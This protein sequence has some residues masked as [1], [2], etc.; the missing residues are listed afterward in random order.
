MA[1]APLPLV[2]LAIWHD[3]FGAV[4]VFGFLLGFVGE[5]LAVGVP[6]VSGWYPPQRQ[7]FALGVYGVGMAGTVI[8]G[9]TAPKLAKV[10]GLG[11][12]FLVG[13]GVLAVLAVVFW[14][15]GRDAPREAPR[16]RRSLLA[17]LRVLRTSGRAWALTPSTS[18]PSAASSRCSSTCPSC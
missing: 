10:A 18:S 13:A 9:L 15:V 14:V 3:S 1:F 7:G 5:S 16:E 12:P 2:A 6:F 17:P 8:A 11:A 4:L